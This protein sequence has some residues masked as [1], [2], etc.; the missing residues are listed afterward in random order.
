MNFTEMRKIKSVHVWSEYSQY[1]VFSKLELFFS[2]LAEQRFVYD[3]Q[4][5]W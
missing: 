1:L 5:H 4:V 2:G 3:G